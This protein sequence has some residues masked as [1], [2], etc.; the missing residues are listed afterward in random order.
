MPV[1]NLKNAVPNIIA[2]SLL[3]VLVPISSAK[4]VEGTRKCDP[5]KDGMIRDGN[6]AISIARLIWFSINPGLRRSDDKIWQSSMTAT[7][8]NRVWKIAQKP[9]PKG[10]IGGGLEIKISGCDGSV[11]GI[12]LTQ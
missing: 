9:M 5:L 11:V 7:L 8:E 6:T 10:S 3:F 12:Y 1:M 2:L 4:D